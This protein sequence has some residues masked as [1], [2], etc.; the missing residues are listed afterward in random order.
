MTE[1]PS[2]T[3]DRAR[4]V[5][6]ELDGSLPAIDALYRH[7]HANPELSGAERQTAGIVA[8][9]FTDAG[10]AVEAGIGGHGV[11]GLLSNGPGPVVAVRADLDALPI[12]EDTGLP[13]ASAAVATLDGVAVPVMHACGHDLHTAQ[14]GRRGR[15]AR[16]APGRLVGHA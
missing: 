16:R 14:P 10:F 2:Q 4:G 3:A 13:Y 8:E 1:S 11:V 15:A 12:A 5:L 7:L 6:R 9:R